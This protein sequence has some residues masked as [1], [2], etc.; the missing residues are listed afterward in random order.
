MAMEISGRMV[1]SAWRA[2]SSFSG[3]SWVA[4]RIAVVLG[5]VDILVLMSVVFFGW[6]LIILEKR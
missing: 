2:W 5:W 4:F 1:R 3:V 6:I